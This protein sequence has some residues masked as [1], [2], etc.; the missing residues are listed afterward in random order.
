LREPRPA[1]LFYAGG[2]F[3]EFGSGLGRCSPIDC[4]TSLYVDER[5]LFV[6][7]HVAI[8]LTIIQQTIIQLTIIQHTI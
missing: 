5:R 7:V 1:H 2:V 3:F 4:T 6:G 8:Q